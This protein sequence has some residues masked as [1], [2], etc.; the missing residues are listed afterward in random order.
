MKRPP[1]CSPD[2]P[3]AAAP[4]RQLVR[5]VLGRDLCNKGRIF[6]V[7]LVRKTLEEYALKLDDKEKL[8]TAS[9]SY[10]NCTFCLPQALE[11]KP[12]MPG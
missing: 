11:P 9:E 1:D 5:L 8:L 4:D 2:D 12:R 7:S 6:C 10:N 3:C